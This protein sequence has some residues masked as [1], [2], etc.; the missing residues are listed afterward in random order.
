MASVEELVFEMRQ[1]DRRFKRACQQL[2]ILNNAI[3]EIQ[4]KYDR[5]VR[6]NQRSCRY[7]TRLRLVTLEGVR[8]M[9]WEY[10]NSRADLLDE[11]QDRLMEEF[12]VDW[13][14]VNAED[15]NQLWKD[16]L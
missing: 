7:L 14:E 1:M 15:D 12:N 4:T 5:A 9:F 3:K 2:V 8:N 13:E 16:V 6:A 10:A 11:M